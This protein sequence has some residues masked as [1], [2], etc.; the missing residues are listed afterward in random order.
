MGA[1]AV[2]VKLK[3]NQ[4]MVLIKPV[5]APTAGLTR[6]CMACLRSDSEMMLNTKLKPKIRRFSISMFFSLLLSAL[7]AFLVAPVFADCWRGFVVVRCLGHSHQCV[8]YTWF[9]Y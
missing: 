8:I 4:R 7:F 6:F 3:M 5:I 9:V 2:H 1:V